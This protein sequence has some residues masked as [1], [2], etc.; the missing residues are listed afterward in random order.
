MGGDATTITLAIDATG[1]FDHIRYRVG[2]PMNDNGR[3]GGTA[4][5]TLPT[6]E[7]PALHALNLNADPAWAGFGSVAPTTTRAIPAPAM[8]CV[9]GS[10][11]PGVEHGSSVT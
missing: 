2:T 7:G 11:R 4:V 10:V 3:A 5:L 6:T 8:A 1:T 9:Q